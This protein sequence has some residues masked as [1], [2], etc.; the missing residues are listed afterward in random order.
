MAAGA[1]AVIRRATGHVAQSLARRERVGEMQFRV[2]VGPDCGGYAAL[3][4]A[5]R[6]FGAE[7]RLGQHDG[8]HGRQS[9]CGHQ[10][11][12]AAADDQRCASRHRR[13]R[14]DKIGHGY[15][16]GWTFGVRQYDPDV[17]SS[18]GVRRSR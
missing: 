17:L 1:A 3:G 10:T 9:Q 4:P 11:G 7:R 6:R 14:P 15:H 12:Q 5:A 16:V 13:G 8:R 18:A 2:V